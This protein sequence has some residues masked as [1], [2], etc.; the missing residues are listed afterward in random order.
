MHNVDCLHTGQHV[1]DCMTE[2]RL[3]PAAAQWSYKKQ[4]RTSNQLR[5]ELS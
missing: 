1:K 5:S 4:T 2:E 3:T